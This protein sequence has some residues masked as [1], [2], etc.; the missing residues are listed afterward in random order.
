MNFSAALA[1]QGFCSKCLPQ[2]I[3]L[4]EVA[5]P[6]FIVKNKRLL[7]A[8]VDGA[9]LGQSATQ[10]YTYE[11]LL[12]RTPI[13]LTTNN[14][15]LSRLTEAELDWVR[16]NCIAVHITEPV[17]EVSR[18]PQPQVQIQPRPRPQRQAEQPP[19]PPQPQPQPRQQQRP[20]ARP[21]V[22]RRPAAAVAGAAPSTSPARKWLAQR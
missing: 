13:I 22:R 14:W 15:D 18:V 10:M 8:H 7:Q 3:L 1:H 5:D 12:W 21:P 9:I 11:V 4:D 17:Y 16:A 19:P 20:L 6:S 2:A